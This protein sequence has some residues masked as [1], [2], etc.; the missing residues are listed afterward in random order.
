[1]AFYLRELRDEIEKTEA[2]IKELRQKKTKMKVDFTQEA[3]KRINQLTC[4]PNPVLT[5]FIEDEVWHFKDQPKYNLRLSDMRIV[6]DYGNFT[7]DLD[8]VDH[9]FW[10]NI[11]TA[12]INRI[13]NKLL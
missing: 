3:I 1:M 9:L 6:I 4:E 10:V 5:T 11:P 12:V 2:T 13:K 8:D 7:A